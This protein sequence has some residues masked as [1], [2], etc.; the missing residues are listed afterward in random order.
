MRFHRRSVGLVV[1]LAL[2]AACATSTSQAIAGS[3]KSPCSIASPTGE[4]TIPLLDQGQD[5]PF[6]LYVPSGY[7]RHRR[8]PLLLNL[9]PSGSSGSQQMEISQM[10][11]EADRRGVA[12]AA[13]NGAVVQGPT[14]YSWNVPGVP[15]ISGTPIPPG[16]PND[17]S[18]LLHVIR[19]AKKSVCIDTDRISLTGYSGGARMASQ[20]ACDHS[21]KIASVSPVAGV[22]AGVPEET[23]PD[24]WAPDMSTCHPTEQ[25]PVQAFHGTADTTNPF[26]GNDDPRW[27]YSVDSAVTRWGKLDGCK[28]K[29][30]SQ[31]TSSVTRILYDK[32][33]EGATVS[34]YREEGAGHTWPGSTFPANGV[35]DTSINAT[36]MIVKLAKESS[37]ADRN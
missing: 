6:L 10:A 33:A 22:R 3:A 28:R 32:C 11:A 19:T 30:T 8:L 23:S 1:A 7:N 18:Y 21:T 12:I 27:G 37:L 5:R 9:H 24:V 25:V 17:E 4:R 31:T 35:I 36:Q 14:N 29:R 16:T 26:F 20:M 2:I 13:P 15:L 34:L